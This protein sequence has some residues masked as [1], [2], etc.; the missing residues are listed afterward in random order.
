MIKRVGYLFFAC[1]F[2]AFCSSDVN[3]TLVGYISSKCE[4]TALNN[5]LKISSEGYAST[6]LVIDC[7]SPMRVSMQSDNG[8]LSYQ[9]SSQIN[10]Y[11][12]TW[13]IDGVRGSETYS[14]HLLKATQYINV[15]DVLFKSIAKLQLELVE[16]LVYAG[17]YQDVIRIEMT[18]SAI[19]G[20]VW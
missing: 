9:H 6:E 1:A 18:P 11:N 5:N 16:P 20:G 8:G 4:F 7:N 14:S 15:G 13:S 19:S 12:V 2:D 3:L 10:S 17:D